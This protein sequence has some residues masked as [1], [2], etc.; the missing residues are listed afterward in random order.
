MLTERLIAARGVLRRFAAC[1]LL[2]WTCIGVTVRA[3]AP[4]PASFP[5]TGGHVASYAGSRGNVA[6]VQL[7]GDYSKMLP[8]GALNVEPRTQISKEFYKNFADQYDFLVVFSNFEFD[9]G[10]AKA[11]YIGVRNDTKGLGTRQFDNSTYFGSAGRLQ[12]YIDMAALSRYHLEPSD[13]RFED[14]LYV[15][16]HEMLHRWAAHVRF[17][18]STGQPNTSLLGRDGSHWSF[19][20]DTGGSVEYGNRWADNG[21]GTFTSKPDRQFYSPLDLYL[22]G[23]LKKEEVPPFFYIES[24]GA[25]ATRLPEAGVIISG[26][27]RDVTIDQVIAAE[28]AREPDAATSQKQFR[29]GFV[30]LTRPDTAASD[31]DLQA[32][33]AVRQAFETRLAAL[34]GGKAL[35]HAF[36]EP[37]RLTQAA[38]PSVLQSAEAVPGASADVNGALTWLRGKQEVQGAWQDN[39]L[40]RLRDTV[41]VASALGNV[42]VNQQAAVDRALSWLTGQRVTNTDYVAR[43]IHSLAARATETDWAQLAAMQN[44]D[45]GWGVAPG[46]QSTPLDTALAVLAMSLDP[47]PARQALARERAKAFLVSKQNTDGGWSHAVSGGSRTATTAQAIRALSMLDAPVQVVSAAR[48]LAARQNPDGGFGDSPSTTHDTAN[49]VLALA[50]AGHLDSVRALDAFR[51]LNATQ[52]LDG[53]WDGSVYATGLAVHALG[54]ASAY[55]WAASSFQVSP[56]SVKDGQRVTLSVLVGNN[57][58]VP[59][60]AT[61]LRVY[62]GDP[63]GAVVVDIPVPPLQPG[64]SSLVRGTW[65]T[66]GHNGNHLLTAVVDPEAVGAE[67]SRVD[68]VA[69]AR[70]AV[71]PAPVEP[72]LAVA[73]TDVQVMPSVVNRLPS[74][75]NVLAQLSNIG[76]TDALGVK[77]RLLMGTSAANMALVDEKV[78]NL[79]GRSTVPVSISVQLT[80]PGRHLL[81]V[82]LDP[83]SSV[84]ESDRTN[85]RAEAAIETVTSYDPAALSGD[86]VVPASTVSVGS[87]VT[88]KATLRNYGTADTPPFQA[89]FTVGDGT[90]TREVERLS[91]QLAA[92]DS[93]TLSLPWRVDLTGTL[94]FKVVVDPLAALADIDRSNNEAHAA[95][96]SQVSVGPNLAV[97]FREF[98]STPDP[99]NE[100]LPLTLKAVLRNIGNQTAQNIEYGFYEGD[101]ATGGVLLA[102]LQVV[103]GLAAGQAAEVSVNLPKVMGTSDR[104]YFVAA[105]PGHKIAEVSTADNTAFRVVE[106]RSLPDLAVSTGSIGVTPGAPKPGDTLTVTVDVQNLG[107]QAARNVVVRLLDGD[108]SAATLAQQTIATV[109]AQTVGRASFSLTLPAQTT[110]RSLTVVLDPDNTVEEGRE[111]NNAATRHL[112]VQSGTAFVSEPYFSP[113]GDGVKDETTFGFR[114]GSA[115]VAKVLVVNE[116]S[117]VVRTFARSGAE[118]QQ[119][120]SVVWDG[121]DDDGRITADGTYRF[122]AQ[123]ADGS[124]QAEATTILDTN[125]TPILRAS[126][127][128]AEYYRNLSCRID[129]LQEWTTSLDEQ[130]VFAFAQTYGN[131]VGSQGLIRISLQG[132]DLTTVVPQSFVVAGGNRPLQQLSA[133]DRGDRVAFTRVIDSTQNTQEIWSVAGDGSALRML[134]TNAAQAPANDRFY[135]VGHLIV[136]P[137]GSA[138][139]ANLFFGDEGG[140]HSSVRRI[141]VN[142]ATGPATVLFDQGAGGAQVYDMAV[143]PNRRRALVRYWDRHNGWRSGLAILDFETG[144]FIAAPEGLYTPV[145]SPLVKWSPDSRHFIL[146]STAEDMGVE[147]GNHIDFDFDVFDSEFNL[148]KRF[149]TAQGPGDDSWY[150]GEVSGPEW[151][152]AGDEFA[153]THDPNPFGWYGETFASDFASS[154]AVGGGSGGSRKTL[155]RANIAQGTLT[156]VPVD[157]SVL[158]APYGGSASNLLLWGPN[159]RTLMKGWAGYTEGDRFI[160][161]HRSIHADTG[162]SVA[163]F[164]KWWSQETNPYSQNMSVSGFAPSGRRLFFT[165]YRDSTNAQSACY[166][167]NGYPQLFAF[168]SLQNL[169]A[170]LQPLRDPRVGGIVVKGTAADLNLTG[171]RIEYADTRTPNDW[172]PV[173]APGSEQKLGTTLATWV[174]PSY[175]T[176]FLRLT[177]SDRAGNSAQALRRVTW[178]DTPAIT[179]L[180]KNHDYISPNGDGVQ[181]RLELSYRVLEPVHLAFEVRREDGTRV[182]MVERDH[183]AIG[184]DFKFEWDGRDDA[185]RQAPDG[186]YT[187]RVLDYEFPFQVDTVPP[188]VQLTGSK[189]GFNFALPPAG[190]LEFA[191]ALDGQRLERIEFSYAYSSSNPVHVTVADAWG[192]Q[193]SSINYP[194]SVGP[195]VFQWDGKSGSNDL[196]E[197]AYTVRFLDS[198][199]AVLGEFVADVSRSEAATRISY[200]PVLTAGAPYD[201]APFGMLT[202][203]SLLDMDALTLE[204]GWG[205]PPA[206]WAAGFK[207]RREQ[208]LPKDLTLASVLSQDDEGTPM[209]KLSGSVKAAAY[210]GLRLRAFTQDRAGNASIVVSDYNDGHD[211]VLGQGSAI[212]WDPLHP[213]KSKTVRFDGVGNYSAAVVPTT[214]RT[215]DLPPTYQLRTLQLEF[216]D[217][218]PT[219]LRRLELRHAF[220]PVPEAT[221]DEPWVPVVLPNEE[222]LSRVQ[223]TKVPLRGLAPT[224]V[225]EGI[226]E[227]SDAPHAI[228]FAWQLPHTRRGVWMWRLVG[229]S[230]DGR[231]LVS[232]TYFTAVMG[233]A[234]GDPPPSSWGTRHEPAQWCDVE[235]SQLASMGFFVP[236]LSKIYPHVV[237]GSRLLHVRADGSK[238]LMSEISGDN[239]KNPIYFSTMASTREWTVGRHSFEA[240]VFSCG[241]WRTVAR[242]F[243]YVNHA[244]PSIQIKA[245]VEGQKM[246]ASRIPT[247]QG[248]AGYLPFEVEVTEPY[249]ASRGLQRQRGSQWPDRGP[250]AGSGE[251]LKLCSVIPGACDDWGP[252]AWSEVP[253]NMDVYPNNRGLASKAATGTM[254]LY[255]MDR[256]TKFELSFDPLREAVTGRLSVYGPSGHLACTQVTVDV[257]GA[258]DAQSVIDRTL[259][260]PNGD[261]VLDDASVTVSAFEP[262]TVKVVIVR[263]FRDARTNLVTVIPGPSVTTLAA[264]VVMNDGDRL[265]PWDGRDSAGHVAPDGGY[266]FRTT[267]VDGCGNEKIDIR[268]LELDNTPPAIAVDSPKSGASVPIEFTVTGT[269]SDLH[270]LRYEAAAISELSPDAAYALPGLGRFNAPH[271]DLAR[272][273][274]AGLTGGARV[275]VKAF[276]GAGNSTTREVPIMLTEPVELISGF[277][278]APNPF[279]PNGDGRREKVSLLYSLTRSAH[280]TLDL[281]RAS[282]GAKIKTLMSR[283]PAPAGNGAAV[284]D[285]RNAVNEIEP[286]EEVAAV[287]TAEVLADGEV[288]A[289][290][291][292]HTGFTLDKTAPQIRFTLPKGPVTTARS[293]VA[294]SATDPLFADATLSLS[295]NGGPFVAIAQAQ[296]ES[297]TLLAGL[298]D[299]PEGPV[300][301]QVKASDRAENEA[302]ET[303]GVIIDRTAPVVTLSTPVAQAYISGLKQPY[304]IEGTVVELHPARY[305]LLLGQGAPPAPQAILFEA[306][307]LPASNKL[308]TWDPR[309]VADG[310][311]TLTLSALDQA[312]LTGVLSVQVT[313]DNTP[314]VAA[315]EASGSPMYV[316]TGTTVKGTATDTNFQSHILA[317][318]PGRIASAS[319]W[320]EIARGATEVSAAALATFQVQPADGSYVLRLI[321]TDKAGN[322]STA[323]QEVIVDNTAPAQVLGLKAELKDR[324]DAHV[325]WSASS[326]AD[327]A[328]YILLRNGSRLNSTLLKT[329][330]YVDPG[331]AAGTYVYTVKAVDHAGNESEPSN[332]GRVVV[333]LSQ[334]VAQ[335]FTPLRDAF[336]AGLVDVRG[337]AAAPADFKEYRLFVGIGRTPGTWQL[338]RRSPLPLTADS[339]AA[340]NSLSLVDGTVVTFRL[341][342][343]DL[344]G[345]I[346]TDSVAV[347]VKNTPPHA[348]IQLQAAPTG[349]NVALTWTPNTEPD[350]QGYLLYRDQQLANAKG[351]V[352]GSLVPYLIK[353]ALYNDLAVP[354]GLH[355]YFVQAM[356]LAG[357]VSDPSNEVEVRIDTRAPHVGIAK[358]ADGS[359]VSQTVALIGESPDTD[360][361]RVQFQ[362]KLAAEAQWTHLAPALTAAPWT[363]EW[364]TVGLP[365]GS[366]QVRAVATDEGGRTDPNPGYITLVLTDLRKPDAPTALAAL[367]TGGNVALSWT[368][369]SS[370]YTAGYH[371]D[372]IEP[373]GSVTRITGTPVMATSYVDTNRPDAGYVYRVVATSAGGTESD[374]SNDAAAVVYTPAFLQPYTPTADS[375]TA[376]AGHTEPNR[377]VALQTA[378]GAEVGYALSDDSGSFAIAAAPL[379]LGDNRFQLLAT[380]GK[381]NTS[382]STALHVRRGMAPAAPTGLSA[383]VS[384]HTVTL[385][386]AANIEPDLAGYVPVLQQQPRSGAITIANA[387]ASSSYPFGSYAPEQA[388]D[389]NPSSGW[390]PHYAQPYVGQWLQVGLATPQVI[391]AVSLAWESSYQTPHQYRVEGYD[392]EVWVPLATLN[393]TDG[394][395]TIEVKL[396]RPYRTHRVRLLV[397]E[398]DSSLPKLNEIRLHALAV[399]ADRTATFADLPDGR[400]H[401]GVLAVSNLGLISP[402]AEALPA[403]GDVN[404]PAAPVLRAQAAGSEVLLSW[405][406]PDDADVTGFQIRRDGALVATLSD[407][408]IRSYVDAARPN[409]RYAYTVT[410]VDAVG[411][412]GAESNVAPVVINVTGPGAAISA[413]AGA[414]AEG[415]EVVVTW[416]VGQGPQPAAFMVLR[417]L[418]AG[419]PYTAVASGVT[420]L[421][422]SDTAVSNGTRYYYV[423]TGVDA[424]GNGGVSSPEVNALAQDRHAPVAPVLT[425]PGRS[426]GPVVTRQAFTPIMGMA[427]PGSRLVVTRDDQSVGST[428]ALAED[429][430]VS[431]NGNGSPFDL[432]ADG[433]LLF[434]VNGE[435]VVWTAD[436]TPVPSASLKSERYIGQFRFSPDGRSAALLSNDSSTGLWWV[437]RWD[438]D[439]DRVTTIGS[440]TGFGQLRF[441]R[442]GTQLVAPGMDDASGEAGFVIVDWAT[443]ASRFVAAPGFESAAWSPDARTLAVVRNGELHLVDVA[444]LNDAV[445]AGIAA[446]G[447]VSWLPDGSALVTHQSNPSGNRSVVRLTLADLTVTPL[448]S[449]SDGD[450]AEPVLSPEG[451]AYLAYRDSSML[452]QRGFDGSEHL[453][454]PSV[455]PY[456]GPAVWSGTHTV[457]FQRYWSEVALRSPAGQFTLPDVSLPVGSSLFSAYAVDEAGNGSAAAA[458]LEVQRRVDTLP[459]WSVQGGFFYPSTPQVGEAT[460]ITLNFR[461]RGT[462]APEVPV[463]VIVVDDQG[464][465]TR[466]SEARL[467][468]LAAG[469]EHATRLS[470]TPLQP[471]HYV[472]IAVVDPH[473]AVDEASKDNNQA[474]WELYVTPAADRPAVQVQTDK[475]RYAGGETVAATVVLVT[476]AEP[477]DGT[478]VTRLVD[479]G[480]TELVKFAPRPVVGLHYGAP[481]T[482]TYAWPSGSTLAGDYRVVAQLSAPHGEPVSDGAAVFA[483]DPTAEFEA[484][485]ITDRQAYTIGD[486]VNASGTVRYVR[487]N[488]LSVSAPAVLSVLATD[489]SVLATRTLDID[490]L[491]QGNDLRMDLAWLSASAGTYSAKLLLGNPAAPLAS[492]SA[493]FAVSPPAVPVIAGSLQVG[494]DVF[495]TDEAITATSR[496]SNS[497]VTL[498]TLPVRVRALSA[499]GEALATWTA[500]LSS[501]ATTPVVTPASLNGPWPLGSFELRLEAEVGSIWTLLDR[502]RVQAA[503]R[504]PPSLAFAAPAAGAIVRSSALVTVVAA[505]RQA[506]LAKVELSTGGGWSTMQPLNLSAGEYGSTGLPAADG[507]LTLQA[508]ASDTLGVTS[509]VVTRAIIIDNTPPGITVA[510]VEHGAS[511][512]ESATPLIAIAELHSATQSITLDDRPYSSGQPVT[513][514]G[515]HTLRVRAS[516]IAGNESE[517]SLTFQIEVPV[518]LNGSL[519]VSPASVAIGEAVVLDA[520]VHNA[521]GM[522]V[523]GVQI[524]LTITDRATGVVLKTFSD[525]ADIVAASDFQRAWSWQAEGKAGALLDVVLTATSQ[526]VTTPIGQGTIQLAAPNSSI[527][528]TASV[529]RPKKLLV[530]VRCPRAED[531]TW[532]NCAA[533]ATRSFSDP[534]TIASC[535]ADRTTWL[536]QY[537]ATVG[538][539]HTVVSDE[540]SFLRE[541]RSGLYSTYWLGGGALKLGSTAAGEVQAAVRRGDTLLVEGWT[542][543][544]NAVLDKVTGASFLGKWST[545]TGTIT[546]TGTVLPSASLGVK[547]PVRLSSS[548]DRHAILNNGMGIVSGNYGLGRSMAFAFDLSGSMRSAAAGT[549]DGVVLAT[550]SYLERTAI[551]DPVGGGAVTLHA[552]ISNGGTTSQ[553]LEHVAKLPAQAQVL[554]TAPQVTVSNVEGGLPTLRWRAT[555]SAGAH[556]DMDTL[557]RVPLLGGDY[558]VS[559]FVNQ[560]Y[561][562]GS[563]TLLQSQQLGVRVL[564]AQALADDALAKVQA[565]SLT[566][567]DAVA[568]PGTVGWLT[569]AAMS[570]EGE[571]WD[572]ALRQLIAAQA[573]LQNVADASADEAKHAIARAIEAVERR[574]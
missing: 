377:R 331:I 151:S 146:Y 515:S 461:N 264:D 145:S 184:S 21:D 485:V 499:T 281:V 491:L 250:V 458:P 58:T 480:G 354:D 382:K 329:T 139:I 95:F 410:A 475:P 246:C 204:Y 153:F 260:S 272:W 83:E 351:L 523:S 534:A 336:A 222:N 170:D 500:T 315:I 137:D 520:R 418:Q 31:A 68:N 386:W 469:A 381:G 229:T 124:V 43:R 565:L 242:P 218:A 452:V 237:A 537:L 166:S 247:D 574:L 476:P 536:D 84:A 252:L 554:Q 395:D 529:A 303:L 199:G 542:A 353:P 400:P 324:R 538:V 179:D 543:G 76:Q 497:G 521:G 426:P 346:A 560:V 32:V 420:A 9:T 46:Y 446:P 455:Y 201:V 347:T 406:G 325:S 234:C 29:L 348:P 330:A 308:Y 198:H 494:G 266:A 245:P 503:E 519:G 367:V 36:L 223:W 275:V 219:P 6:V 304:S 555:A 282:N 262:I 344:S 69:T 133:S 98:Q 322:E 477:F 414:P 390:M 143:A 496:V 309:T 434:F 501:V 47:N 109:E 394:N 428:T 535:T 45:G 335:I 25:N 531:D 471:G 37:K 188:D 396:A 26:V 41:V 200:R 363:I 187:L 168:E 150:S 563:T 487:G 212:H 457:A 570:V 412:A 49:V 238:D 502:A 140:F 28:G 96:S 316:R 130:S 528:L 215:P 548:G 185:G 453:I 138:V 393:N 197:G 235:P 391:D 50:A 417:G 33:N 147:A 107:Q 546:T 164:G 240:Q 273:N 169:V 334:P 230:D 102:P 167:P 366:Y 522:P 256:G 258:V 421:S 357:N 490:G 87:D 514:A 295:V 573:A 399:G 527:G 564:S 110:A 171:Y 551:A 111:D 257:D 541:L 254:L 203:D 100:G 172:H 189:H 321:V 397:V 24:P 545:L 233:E 132:G 61:T 293:G 51:F 56:G 558:L 280:L 129:G 511:Y 220:V 180:I 311:Y 358:P 424:L 134:A 380:D 483:I 464:L 208:P 359:K 231:D 5:S 429:A 509:S 243:L 374:P 66:F 206:D 430:Y 20:L 518:A 141:P 449:P 495:A 409:G 116:R 505:A 159:D 119:E 71:A 290:Q 355:R 517:L 492:A 364:S 158:A 59:A 77:V 547:T 454:H 53:S 451:D 493:N 444:S 301:L 468:A 40:T 80:K 456:N 567:S 177:V 162:A 408:A 65:S 157:P 326:E 13:P 72:D 287:L 416:T 142:P 101:P 178:S 450:Y 339:L 193:Q 176:F 369:S 299:V 253:R 470:W 283:M 255:G 44:T 559:S 70:L 269:V 79:L 86:L 302:T 11:F 123:A 362:Y 202:K 265:F 62:D 16:A 510:G 297:G 163:L 314:P 248:T 403:V 473:D 436:G 148:Q 270:P 108:A 89:V 433:R 19:L 504:T 342:A 121:R 466:L 544:R 443:L 196:P 63:S 402:I 131:P 524:A 161:G 236:K 427:E 125:R 481:Q 539:A 376:I 94:D 569:R 372:R 232:N 113:N 460:G 173:A 126:G 244:P 312:E 192:V 320:S 298:E 479:S 239:L 343:E 345:Q 370:S 388:I 2:L 318:A 341:E 508:R 378:A 207:Q 48:F 18:D 149:R 175:G 15:L 484:T 323:L 422:Y 30:L 401:V 4:A 106:V 74:T 445:V 291:V 556:V 540:A 73:T 405:N 114:L 425:F 349:N 294:A 472:V 526:G 23:M 389:G 327:V 440:R 225:R 34:T 122:R 462:A 241:Q 442:E 375:S 489:G 182:R 368:A 337:T 268:Y 226:T 14:V 155:Y 67:L 152:S 566:G 274:T 532:D 154:S 431:I 85:N 194:D 437:K 562:N 259:F 60:P 306:T 12:G 465:I 261:G 572:D 571:Q 249:G 319:R 486:A 271:I 39:P 144:Q 379:G 384:S 117:E 1:A 285:G 186:K 267:M 533:T 3:D 383:G 191:S 276:D 103:S 42:G 553:P 413:R 165:T 228:S 136:T 78:V 338:L 552:S 438:A 568:K 35:A 371:I 7:R 305:Q 209:A 439:A 398:G 459:D 284:W 352:I 373:N 217:N 411:N 17:I 310:P 441:S 216:A 300:R 507:P 118:P 92:G 221:D 423:V 181:D 214:T 64:S 54:A 333:S 506:P 561:I 174:P 392:G 279:S 27:R 278:P 128:P 530:Y 474:S 251:E 328:G 340:W 404:P 127:T 195:H 90:T 75:V 277:N 93:K 112:T 467:P 38:D 463:S 365:H 190:G 288:T 387:S 81:A 211:L 513:A 104:L 447:A 52:H 356:D 419:G 57:G 313:V 512:R 557:L 88:L 350:L 183:A 407:A 307:G 55:N 361:V 332:E 435:S 448:T 156:T 317:L 498:A 105:D 224:E 120:G 286:D 360:I 210:A 10:D 289:R 205:D 516:D 213:E 8:G 296:D 432:S 292:A 525:V 385:S 91:V 22:M 97:S 549:W 99:A 227:L 115:T 478:L 263:A 550:L 415:G 482:Y 160:D 488:L 135:S 82:V